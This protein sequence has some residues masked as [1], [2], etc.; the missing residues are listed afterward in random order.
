MG[1]R[2]AALLVAVA[3]AMP[4]PALAQEPAPIVEESPGERAARHFAAKEWDAAIE[5]LVEAY[6]LDP[7]PDYLYARAQAERFRGRCDVAIALYEHYVAS[8]PGEQQRADAERHIVACRAQLQPTAPPPRV[9]PAD[10]RPPSETPKPTPARRGP[11][12]A[13]IALVSV[14]AVLVAS[15]A[16]MWILGDRTRDRATRSTNEEGY[17]R[18]KDRGRALTITGAVVTSV[19][20]ALAIGGAVRF[21]IVARGDRRGRRLAVA[22]PDQSATQ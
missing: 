18:A 19:G 20:I 1:S 5:A 16:T 13:A 10:A 3:L 12:A 4:V 15:G 17:V 22:H 8:G 7:D 11:D 6:A 14:A 9:E 2:L 21:G